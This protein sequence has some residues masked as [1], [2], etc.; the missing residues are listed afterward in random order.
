MHKIIF[1]SSVIALGGLM[2]CGDSNN[3]SKTGR[4]AESAAQQQD[5]RLFVMANNFSDAEW[6]NGIQRKDGRANVFYFIQ[7]NGESLNMKVGDTLNF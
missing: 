2:A 3:G 1:I 7:K 4:N 5:T 6:K